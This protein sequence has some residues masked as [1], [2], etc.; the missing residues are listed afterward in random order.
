MACDAVLDILTRETGRFTTEI[1]N[2]V[3]LRSLWIG[4]PHKDSFPEGIGEIITN[5]TYERSAPTE[6]VPAW[7]PV[8]VVDGQEG[9]ACLPPAQK[10]GIG[11]TTRTWSLFRRVLEGPD[12]CV[13]ELRTPFALR[14]QLERVLDILAEYAM[15][16]WEIRYRNEYFRTCNR[17][18]VV[19]GCPASESNTM[20]TTYPAACPTSP[21]TQGVLNRYKVKLLRDGAATSAMGMMDGAPILTLIT[22]PEASDRLIFDNSDIRQ[23]LR[24]GKP[25]EL[26]A[27]YGVE[28]SYRGFYHLL[29]PYN[30]RFTCAGGTYTQVAPFASTAATKGQ[31]SVVNSS[32]EMASCEETFV[33][34]QTVFTSRIPRPITNPAP[35]FRFDPVNYMGD[36]RLKN[37]LDRTCNPDGTIVYHRGILAMAGEPVH[38]ERGIAF[39]HLRCD[40][41]CN[42]VNACS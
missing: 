13:E 12:F 1:Y 3:F 40:P 31:K 5:L 41:N 36:W 34:D 2:R 16:E 33:F 35:N 6:A 26:L 32:W 14:A 8:S 17:K 37:I 18:V 23:D 21:I 38:P 19:D 27:P 22:S 39:T 24:F 29:D 4:L 15:I 42:L 9:G 30:R 28:R 20:A 10:V 25:S 7:L 11:S